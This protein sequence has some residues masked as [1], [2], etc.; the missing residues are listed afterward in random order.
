MHPI[1]NGLPSGALPL[2]SDLRGHWAETGSPTGIGCVA[3]VWFHLLCGTFVSLIP[4]SGWPVF[5][6]RM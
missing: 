6:S 5:R 2:K 1:L 3:A 4:I